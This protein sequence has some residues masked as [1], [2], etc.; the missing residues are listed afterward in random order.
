MT[1][2]LMELY[3]QFVEQSQF[4]EAKFVA[5]FLD[6]TLYSEF[7]RSG[8]EYSEAVQYFWA[9]DREFAMQKLNAWNKSLEER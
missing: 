2:E 7:L 4:N 8:T 5:M 1:D 6:E 3:Q 9:A